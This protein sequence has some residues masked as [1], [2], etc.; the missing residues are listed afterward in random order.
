MNGHGHANGKGGPPNNLGQHD[1]GPSDEAT[2][3]RNTYLNG[4]MGAKGVNG[5]YTNG[6]IDSNEADGRGTNPRNGPIDTTPKPPQP[7]Q[8]VAICGMACRLPGGIHSPSELWAFLHAGRDARGPVPSSRYNISAFHSPDKKP[9]SVIS[10]QGYFLDSTNDL[11]ALDTSFF[12]MPRSEVETLDPQQRMLLEVTREALDDAGETGW[13]GSNIG[14]YVGSYGQDWYDV[15]VRDTQ[16]H[17]IYQILGPHDFMIS[18]RISHELDL[19]GPSMTV[20]TACSGSLI[21]VNEACMAIARGDCTSAIVGGTNIIMAPAVTAAETQQGVLS[22]DGS[23]N[24]F[25]ANANGYARGEGIVAIYLKPLEDAIR[26]GNPVRAVVTGSATNHNGHTSTVAQPSSQAQVALIKQAY[27]NAGITD[28]TRTG[29]FECH[30][31][32]TRTGDAVELAAVAACFG[33][34]GVH[35]GSIK[36]NLGHA[37]GAAGL[38]GIL[39]AVLVLEN[40]SIPPQIKSLPLNPTIDANLIVSTE[41]TPWPEDRDE[42]VSVSSFGLGG[43]NAHAIIE[44]AARFNAT[45]KFETSRAAAAAPNTPHLL[46]FS[47][48]TPSSLTATVDKYEGFLDKSPDL[49]PD[50]A[51]TLANKREHLQY[52]SFAV[53]TSDNITLASTAPP[54]KVEQTQE[55][56][57]IMVFTGQGAQ[58]A[59]M[60]Y[61]LLRSKTNP[62]FSNTIASLDKA[63]QELGL[64]APSWSID[65]ELRKPARKSRVDEAEFSQPLCTALQIALVDSYASIGIRPAA[66]VGHSS[67]EIAAAYAAGGLSAHDA[68]IVSYL[69]G[70]AVAKQHIRKGAMA[71]LGMSWEAARKRLVPGV[72]LAC[73]NAPNS[74]TISGDAGLVIETVDSIKKS[75]PGVP[76]TVLK[77]DKAYHSPHMEE[78]GAK[79]HAAMTNAGVVGK[80]HTVPF[81]SSVEGELLVPAASSRFGPKYWQTNLECSVLFTSAVSSAIERHAGPSTQVFLEVGPH[82]ALAGPLRQI[83]THKSSS[84]SYIST[85]TRRNDSAEN[86][87]SALGQLFVHHVPFN[88]QDLMPAGNT[89]SDLPPYPWDHHRSHW[90]ESRIAREWRMRKYPHHD[91]LGAKVPDT[92]DLEPVWRNLLHIENAPWIRDHKINADIIFPFA[93]YVA[94]AAEAIRQITGVEEA[95]ELRN[96]VVPTALVL[97]ENSPKEL[98]TSFHHL[99]LTDSLD[100]DWWEFRIASHNGNTWIKHC[101]GEI[102]AREEKNAMRNGAVQ[103][104]LPRKVSSKRWY[105]TMRRESIDYGHHFTSLENITTATTGARVAQAQV[106]NNWHGDEQFYHLHPVIFDSYLQLLSIAARYGLTHDYRQ[107]LPASVGS[108][109]LRRSAVNNLVVSAIAEPVGSGVCGTGTIAAGDRLII[110]VSNVRLTSFTSGDSDI[111]KSAPITARSEWVPHIETEA[112]STLVKPTRENQVYAATLDEL[113][114]HSIAASRRSTA[115]L[116]VIPELRQY[117]AWLDETPLCSEELDDATLNSRI[118]SLVT[119]LKSTPVAHISKAITLVTDNGPAILSGQKKAFEVFDTED[120][121]GKLHRFLEEFDGSTFFNRLGHHKPNLRVLELGAGIGS[122]TAGIVKDLTRPDGQ[123]LFSHYMVSDPSPGMVEALKSR[124]QGLPNMSFEAFDIGTDAGLPGFVGRDFDLVIAAGVLH[125]T[126][127]LSESLVRIRQLLAPSGR[128]LLQSLRPGLSWSRY[129][130]SLLPAWDIGVDDDRAGEP[131][132]DVK[133]WQERLATA[134]LEIASEPAFDSD[135]SSHISHVIVAKPR[136]SHIPAKKV[137]I[138]SE[139]SDESFRSHLITEELLAWGYE[140]S[141]CSLTDI[142][143]PSQDIIAFL[144]WPTSF[145]EHLDTTKFEMLKIFID[146]IADSGILWITQPSQSHCID[147]SFA[148]IHGLARC[149]RSEL[150]IAFATCEAD[151]LESLQG[152]QAVAGVFQS[153]IERVNDGEIEPDFEYV[154]EKGLTRVNRF[155]PLSSASE[156]AVVETTKDA[157]LTIA[158]PGRLNTLYWGGEI[159]NIP[160]GDEVQVEIHAAGLNFRD[161][162]VAMGII[163][164]PTPTF[165]YEATGIVRRVGPKAEKLGV[166]D[167]VALTGVAVFASTVTTTEK[168]CERLPDELDFTDGA[169]MPLVY[170]TAI[171]SL[172]NVGRLEKGQSIL[173]HSGCGGV[174]LAA[175]QLARMIGAEVYTTVSSE[176]KIEHLVREFG[177]S[178]D[179]IFDSRSV[180][181]EGDLLRE[182][183][184]RGVDL[185]L[186]S[187]SGELLHATWRCI[188]KWGTL[189]EIGKRDLLGAGKLN[190]EVF[191]ANRSYRCVDIDQMCKERPEMIGR[192][193]RSMMGF[194]RDGHIRSIS[195]DKIFPGS[196]MQEAF[197]HMQQGSHIGKIVLQVRNPESGDLHLGQIQ[198]ASTNTTAVLDGS[199]SYLLVGGLGGLG[200]SVAVW[201]IQN[202]A[203]SLIFLSRSAGTTDQDKLFVKEVQSMGCKVH[204]V[205]GSVTNA[206]D[207]ARAVAESPCPLKGILQMTMVLHDRA[208]GKM[209]IDEWNGATAPKVKGTWNLHNE[210]Q[211]LNLDFFILFSSLSGIVGQPGQANYASANTFLDAFVKFRT[212]KGLPC[213]S[214]NIGAVEGAGYLVDND[215]LLKKMKGTGWRAVQESELLEVL[216]TVMRRSP[217]AP[218]QDPVNEDDGAKSS[219]VNSNC[220]LIGIAPVIPLSSPDSSARLRKDVRMSVFHNIRSQFKGGASSD[221]LQQFLNAAKASPET[222]TT[223]ESVIFLSRE[224]G[225]KLLGLVLRPMDDEI[226][227][228]LS[229]AQ[230]GLDSMVAVE[231]RAWWKQIFGLDISILEMLSMVTLEALG[232]QAAEGL[233]VLHG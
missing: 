22:T 50:V 139:F 204:L 137:T 189:V 186:N 87:L 18:N 164:L 32:G 210:T 120:T 228:S 64:L 172:I 14:V 37:E 160:Q 63:L 85:L 116:D 159:M 123:V 100:S 65:E 166:G 53:C 207:V 88:L 71:A 72:V 126:P 144:D 200:R 203:R 104:D 34:A 223:P 127:K 61:E 221:S 212:S 12:S 93:G 177:I 125:S 141:Y 148:Q 21:G 51:Y 90:S 60:G 33:K 145:L 134:D 168:L 161:V 3:S 218:G 227:V 219:L 173:I 129:V 30:G 171:Y 121:L 17:G 80:V 91:L 187:L 193:L 92:T 111:E 199:A 86:W 82:A 62:V 213:T 79:Y 41:P 97:N 84:A 201:M 163:E 43:S 70:L 232:K 217:S 149:I 76:A 202:G 19:H 179:H 99:R 56:S 52:R 133:V 182:T 6:H 36:A 191:L 124:F 95:V 130:L 68:I 94:M 20:R 78:I 215:E 77:V 174:G 136:R 75:V 206:S 73:D 23:C 180:S 98:V 46:L 5:I 140:V 138:L 192:L 81:F 102:L 29:F 42:R 9:G 169:T 184:G 66:V 230:L 47:A 83:I 109:I 158:Q 162:L 157:R 226:D 132:V 196:K 170:A 58:W 135:E 115:G 153:F 44:S 27:R 154:I 155:F 57:L 103:E 233:S 4:T 211:S 54:T 11:A 55:I 209:T 128:L 220:T 105:D 175:I 181:F 131:Y 110:E 117:K 143:P 147:P 167:R 146:N 74:V 59:R 190:M 118:E 89:L 142:P 176:K 1:L 26:D 31:T 7:F 214:L 35:I 195:I 16:A 28:I 152:C 194:F 197:Q 183:N 113:V 24:T 222:L 40:R 225:K 165:G 10:Q 101:S 49:L 67:G 151:D 45:R 107:V 114:S 178:K 96:V 205:R 108:L 112:F 198:S 8:P 231:M 48:N 69:R 38:V 13:R 229:L 188:A 150:G 119:S 106:R 39:K 224:I 216:G 156:A 15:S 122:A 2:G 185:A 25:S 208:W